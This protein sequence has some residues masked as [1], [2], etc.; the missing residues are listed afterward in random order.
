MS[1]VGEKTCPMCGETIKA[2]ARK[3]RYCGEE[4]TEEL[5]PEYQYQ[6]EQ[7]A[8]RLVREK[9]DNSTAI[10]IF[11]TGLLGCLAPVV[12]IYGTIFLLL[13]RSYSFPNKG[14]AIAGT[15]LAWV[16]TL[17]LVAM[18]VAGRFNQR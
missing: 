8:A 13:R 11:I 17:L 6:I 16:W 15:I 5:G 9:Q 7:A 18:I 3:C 12:A 10:Q 4:L 14:L 1:T 2:A